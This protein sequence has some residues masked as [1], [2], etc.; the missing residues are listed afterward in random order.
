MKTIEFELVCPFPGLRSFTEEESL[1]FKGRDQQIEQISDLLEQNKFLMLTGASGEGK[2]SLIY[3][4]LIPNARAGFFKAHYTNWVVADFRP[5]RSPVSNMAQAVAHALNLDKETVATELKRGFSS[6]VDLYVNSEQYVDEQDA[7][8]KSSTEAEK[9]NK[10]RKAANLLIIVDQFEEFFTNPENFSND[11]PS[12]DSQVVINLVLETA[13]IALKR[14][15]PIYMV[16]TMRSDFIG[17]C[18]AFR[19]LPEYIGFSQF[20]VPRLKRKDFKQVIEEPTILSGNRISQRLIERLVYDLAE[21]VDQLP[22]LQHALS[23]I[24]L[25]ADRGKEEMDLIH[26][27][28]VGGMPAT[29]LPDEDQSKFTDWFET[30]PDFKR[31]F[32][33]ETGLHKIIEF[34]ANTLYEGA[35]A[36]YGAIHSE[37]TITAK[38]AKRIIAMSFACLTKIDNSRA[39]RNRMTLREI[40]TIINDPELSIQVVGEVL[41]IFREEANSFIRPYKTSD[42]ATHTLSPDSVL[43]ITHEALIRNWNKLDQ[44]AVNEFDFYTNWLDF[45]KQ[46]SRWIESGKSSDYLLPIGPLTYF[47]TWYDQCKP[48]IG[49]IA[50]YTDNED[51]PVKKLKQADHLLSETKEYLKRSARKVIV[52]RTFMKYGTQRVAAFLA[53]V[54]MLVLSGFYWNDAENKRNEQVIEKLMSKAQKLVASEEVSSNEKAMYLIAR[55]RFEEGTLMPFLE[56]VENPRSKIAIAIDAYQNFLM[57][58]NHFNLPIK[59]Q[60]SHF[61]EKELAEFETNGNDQVFLL[62]QINKYLIR[63]AYDNYYN[64]QS[65]YDT[66]ISSMTSIQFKSVM[67]FYKNTELFEATIPTE[68]NL[69]IQCWLTLGTKPTEPQIKEMLSIISPFESVTGD[70][71]FRVYYAKGSFEPDGNRNLDFSGGYHT[72]ASLY[73][74]TGNTDKVIAC[75]EKSKTLPE[76]FT[77]RLFNNYN[78]IIGYLYQYGHRDKSTSVIKWLSREFADNTPHS[79]Y[80]NMLNRSGYLSRM[81]FVNLTK[82]S[83]NH[84]GYMYMNLYLA[85]RD[86]FHAIAEDYQ[87]ILAALPNPSE[88][89][90]LLAM[91]YKRLAMFEHKYAF[92]RGISIDTSELNLLLDKAWQHFNLVDASY[93]EKVVT[94]AIGYWGDGIRQAQIS[95]R[96]LFIYPDYM[97]GWFSRTYHSDLFYAYMRDRKLLDLNFKSEQDI[98][99]IYFW[100]A[101]AY[102][103][104]PEKE[105]IKYHNYYPLSDETLNNVSEFLKAKGSDANLPYLILA[106]RS[107]EK[108]DTTQGLTYYQ[109]IDFTSLNRSSD[110]FE[111][112]EKTFFLNEVKNLSRNMASLSK[113]KEAMKLIGTF[114]IESQ[115][116]FSFIFNAEKLYE[117]DYNPEAFG[118]LD[119]A[120]VK[121]NKED[122]TALRPE[123]DYRFK[124]ITLLGQIGGEKLNSLSRGI[125]QDFFEFD[126]FEGITSQIRGI[127]SEG[128]YYAA[129]SVM[130]ST[131]TESQE[132][133]CYYFLLWEACKTREAGKPVPAW[134]AMDNFF[135][136]DQEYI[137]YVPF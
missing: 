43:D 88:R 104:D 97:D 24:W 44:W 129:V 32:F 12:Q 23:Q 94:P 83:R 2:S 7:I 85:S 38:N 6:L 45:K 111:Y 124:L 19:G 121:M 25:A 78:N 14:N 55:E 61:I 9:K 120:I 116:A 123:L 65:D 73:G 13:R 122:F 84:R 52:S 68:L 81:F 79:V 50:R 4:G 39:V 27:A 95:N 96:H 92:D 62:K 127:A 16:C 46:L 93:L 69:A 47:E 40:T 117:A 110:R 57:I 77:G 101:K 136:W 114:T 15:L 74:A 89:N 64:P 134:T 58:D 11:T 26:Y 75:F 82:G 102:E 91:H 109:K 115:K 108:L 100:L 113:S 60:L 137:F 98:Q 30:Q 90:F 41:T 53:I 128:N 66:R 72:L 133:T 63:A 76:Y 112:L 17:Q 125:V 42:P 33:R 126:K 34:H 106:N 29:E 70:S 10:K 3:A 119:S 118:W 86:Q 48:N 8:W 36:R 103:I 71:I 51:D 22:V 5:E 21:G 31:E 131:L 135:N 132:L 49:W 87:K 59:N 54:L 18:V 67:N 35:W 20:F 28:M 105:V 107:F 56:S 99:Y 130:P 1:Y 80:K 37:N